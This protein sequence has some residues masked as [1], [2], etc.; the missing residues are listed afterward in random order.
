M[1]NAVR[2]KE[3]NPETN[4]TTYEVAKLVWEEAEFNEDK[5]KKEIAKTKRKVEEFKKQYDFHSAKLE[6]LLAV[7]RAYGED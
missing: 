5:L 2:I 7:Y 4:T 3:Y 1:K 6:E